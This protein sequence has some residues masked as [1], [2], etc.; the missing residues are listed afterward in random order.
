MD[1]PA[2]YIISWKVPATVDLLAL[3]SALVAA[4][5]AS[6]LAPD[7]KPAAL[8]ARTSGYIAKL[9]STED[10]KKLSRPAGHAARQL[11][12]EE[13]AV[14]ST[15][16]TYTKEASLSLASDGVT[17]LCDDATLAL[18]LPTTSSEVYNSRTA[19]DVTRIVQA[20]V[21]SAGSDLIPV[22]EQGGAYFI[23][24]GHAVIAQVGALLR[25]IGGELATF[26]CSLGHGTE[27]SVSN[28]ITDYMLKQIGELQE[29][30]EELN[31]KGIRADVKSRR[32]SRV[33]ELRERVGAYATLVGASAVKLNTAIDVAEA[34]LLAKLGAEREDAAA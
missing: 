12:R 3:R 10:A 19:S 7:L 30:V 22:R 23:P 16:L 18:M 11:T 26:A 27:A 24:S 28:C 9:T 13:H 14:G 34:T 2:G 8:V 33:A 6:D 31:E 20:V 1:T 15:D 17:L 32:L 4:G 25:G 21:A 29:A 5:L